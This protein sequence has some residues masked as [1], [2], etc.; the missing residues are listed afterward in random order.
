[1]EDVVDLPFRGDGDLVGHVAYTSDDVERT[2]EARHEFPRRRRVDGEVLR[3]QEYL[4]P[5]FERDMQMPCIVVPFLGLLCCCH[6]AP[7]ARDDGR[8]IFKN[9]GWLRQCALWLSS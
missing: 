7:C 1:M 3:V 9:I 5:D 4:L 2:G 6:I 8:D